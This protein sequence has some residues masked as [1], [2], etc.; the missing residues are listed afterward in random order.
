VA[1]DGRVQSF[2]TTPDITAKLKDIQL[3]APMKAQ[4]A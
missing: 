4:Q 2:K 1:M 3:H